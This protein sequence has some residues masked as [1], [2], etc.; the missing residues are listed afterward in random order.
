MSEQDSWHEAPANS[1]SAEANL[2]IE[3]R[4]T[5]ERRSRREAIESVETQPRKSIEELRAAIK[6]LLGRRPAASEAAQIEAQI[7]TLGQDIDAAEAAFRHDR[8]QFSPLERSLEDLPVGRYLGGDSLKVAS[9]LSHQDRWQRIED[10][11]GPAAEVNKW[12]VEDRPTEENEYRSRQD[13]EQQLNLEPLSLDQDGGGQALAYILHHSGLS[14]KQVK[15][16]ERQLQMR[17]REDNQILL[18]KIKRIAKPRVVQL[19]AGYSKRPP[20]PEEDVVALD[21]G[22]FEIQDSLKKQLA[23][24]PELATSI[25]EHAAFEARVQYAELAQVLRF[26]KPTMSWPTFEEVMENP[27]AASNRVSR[28]VFG[29]EENFEELEPTAVELLNRFEEVVM[30]VEAIVD[31]RE[32][33]VSN[34]Q[35]TKR[36][37]A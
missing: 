20:T 12:R 31:A 34:D 3:A 26:Y 29:V 7:E 30:T 13:R 9:E 19:E 10:E 36:Q 24:A 23:A 21:A 14:S 25:L 15:Q 35:K 37:A 1:S 32:Q 11:H 5:S 2:S 22:P 4:P 28:E 33:L 16:F 17:G 6:D 18:E 27:E 8:Q